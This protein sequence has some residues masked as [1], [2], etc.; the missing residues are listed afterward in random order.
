MLRL[1]ACPLLL[2]KLLRLCL[3][4]FPSFPLMPVRSLSRIL[5]L[6]LT[7]MRISNLTPIPLGV[8]TVTG[9]ATPRSSG[10]NNARNDLNPP[11]RHIV[12]NVTLGFFVAF[13]LPAFGLTPT[14]LF[15]TLALN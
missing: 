3:S 4:Q 9:A 1:L 13:D 5:M 2:R 15:V 7:L 11:F 12:T 10:A 6:L 14:V 8:V